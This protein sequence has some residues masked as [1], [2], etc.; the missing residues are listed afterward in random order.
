M[1]YSAKIG[2]GMEWGTKAKL[3]ENL[4][5]NEL[6][7]N[8]LIICKK[9]GLSMLITGSADADK[10]KLGLINTLIEHDK[11]KRTICLEKVEEGLEENKTYSYCIKGSDIKNVLKHKPDIIFYP[12]L[13]SDNI[14][15]LLS[16]P[17]TGH[18]LLTT[19]NA[20]NETEALCRIFTICTDKGDFPV[21]TLNSCFDLI[22]NIGKDNLDKQNPYKIL[23][24]SVPDIENEIRVK[25]IVEYDVSNKKWILKN[26]IPELK[27]RVLIRTGIK[28]ESWL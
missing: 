21:H 18:Q 19:I 22:I 20:S 24:I 3:L 16:F 8:N 27:E 28:L 6:I 17:I 26:D 12:E 1:K 13:Y 2:I 5:A 9:A 25:K 7:M 10:V 14:Y 4:L 23:S 15:E 11:D